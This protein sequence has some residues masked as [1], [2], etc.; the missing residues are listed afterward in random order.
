MGRMDGTVAFVTG[1]ARGQGASHAVWLA[2][3]AS[4]A[5]SKESTR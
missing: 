5:W 1:A 3:E 4:D 2:Q